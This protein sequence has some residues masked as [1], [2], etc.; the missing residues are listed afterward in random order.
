MFA[1]GIN[2]VK[3]MSAFLAASHIGGCS[4]VKLQNIENL[5]GFQIFSDRQG[6]IPSC[7][8]PGKALTFFPGMGGDQIMIG[9]GK[10]AYIVDA[11]DNAEGPT[12][13]QHDRLII[14]RARASQF[15]I[16]RQ[17]SALVMCSP[18]RNISVVIMRQYC[19]EYGESGKWNNAVEEITF[20]SG[21][22]WLSDELYADYKSQGFYVT[23]DLL[24]SYKLT[25]LSD[26]EVARW[27]IYKL[28]R[29]IPA[30]ARGRAACRAEYRKFLDYGYDPI[31]QPIRRSD[32]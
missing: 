32:E 16:S 17:G 13:E 31:V 30:A 28:S 11:G 15:S 14:M 23:R 10:P 20:S 4:A 29:K 1:N 27:R 24:K 3:V 19:S 5:H 18:E 9:P 21:E 22:T 12:L 6:D 2:L 25:D 8:L 7:N 26:E